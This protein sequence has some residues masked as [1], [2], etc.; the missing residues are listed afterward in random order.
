[1]ALFFNKANGIGLPLDISRNVAASGLNINVQPAT[2][3]AFS[4]HLGPKLLTAAL[5]FFLLGNFPLKSIGYGLLL[6]LTLAAVARKI[7][8]GLSIVA[9]SW[10][11]VLLWSTLVASYFWSAVP[12][13]TA[14]VIFSQS[15]FLLFALSLAV[16]HFSTGFSG[17]LKLAAKILLCLVIAYTAINPGYSI[18]G[19][20][21]RSFFAQKNQLGA[22]M[23]LSIL[24][25][26]FASSR[27]KLDFVWAGLAVVL[28][29]FSLSKTAIFLAGICVLLTVLVNASV[30]KKNVVSHT[31]TVRQLLGALLIVFV[32]IVLLF[33]V[34][35]RDEVIDFFWK[36]IT[37]ELFT[38]RGRLWLV[39]IQQVRGDSL[40]G[41]G[42]GVLWQAGGA[43]EIV[44]TTLY[45]KDPYWVQRMVSSDG[46][47]IDLFASLGILGV[48]LF[49]LTAVDLYRRLFR[50]WKQADSRLIFALVTFVL[51]HGIT[52]STILYSTNILWLIYLLC[53]F[54]V[55][56]YAKKDTTPTTGKNKSLLPCC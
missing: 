16:V 19:L 13:A 39:V 2:H 11:L 34:V 1:M 28:L 31:V 53:Y 55:A 7:D 30:S 17:S 47:Y 36:T 40:L 5:L 56:G 49:L 33:M 50:Q 20:G 21:L 51:L 6:A 10:S 46:S 18:S 29:G 41:I 4:D 54:R 8:F 12:S 38:G 43:S 48:A 35:Y 44:Q 27:Q 32:G 42:P 25:F 45:Q 24:G 15:V 22:M 3:P 52:E 9:S 26:V 14:S 23:G 37:N